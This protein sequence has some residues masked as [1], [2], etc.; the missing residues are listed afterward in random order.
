MGTDQPAPSAGVIDALHRAQAR[1]I[2]S[3]GDLGPHLAHA[4]GFVAVLRDGERPSSV[5][6]LGSGGGLPGLVIADALEGA[7]VVLLES[8][9]SRCS[10][11]T[12]AVERCGWVG[13]VRVIHARAEDA[14]HEKNLRGRF[15]AVVARSFG[16]PSVTA[17]CGSPFLRVEGRLVVSEP[18]ADAGGPAV[19]TRWPADG[20]ALVGLEVGATVRGD[21]GYQVLRRVADCPD[22]YPRRAGVPA[23][24]P[25]F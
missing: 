5:L 18:P 10:L 2:V 14:A 23:K 13:R 7:D 3:R 11:L 4:Y 8:S 6:D 12:E 16:A 24:R 17:E 21:F 15:D 25:L 1:G 20:V 19:G 9:A 22:R